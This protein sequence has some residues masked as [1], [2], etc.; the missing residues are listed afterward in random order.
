[1]A[2]SAPLRPVPACDRCGEP[3]VEH[4]AYAGQHLCGDHLERYVE[5]R[6]KRSIRDQAEIE[7]GTLA[8]AVSGGKDSLV[9]LSLLE[10]V[11]GVRPDV[12]LV[13]VTVDE[14]IEGYRAASLD[15][16]RSLAKQLGVRHVTVAYED[17]VDVTMDDLV[18]GDRLD[19]TPCATCGVLRRRFLR[20]AAERVE[21]DWLA[22]GHNLDDVA[23]SILMN[24]LRGDVDRLARMGPHDER[25]DGMAPRV[26][27][28]RRI[29]EREVAIYAQL[30]GL[31]VQHDECP[32]N[33]LAF[34]GEIRDILHDLEAAH[35]GTRHALVGFQDR[36]DP[37][38]G[39]VADGGDPAE[40]PR[41]GGPSSGGL[42]RSCEVLE[43]LGAGA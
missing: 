29:P 8:V 1:M 34:R 24:V 15:H 32:H 13:A 36:I 22:T 11:F 27:P 18:S 43:T 14:G 42:C 41:C 37:V 12:E 35:P 20:A 21:A 6:A 16:A 19:G 9:C 7:D 25:R 5:R 33:A 26:M 17:R 4:L 28:L 3:A 30:V 10:R 40:C 2:A 23:Q 38:L 31:P 39:R